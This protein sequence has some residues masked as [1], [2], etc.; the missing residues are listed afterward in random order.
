VQFFTVDNVNAEYIECNI[1]ARAM[2]VW[3]NRREDDA[4]DREG[5]GEIAANA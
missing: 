2:D 5:E 3:T 1:N 4:G